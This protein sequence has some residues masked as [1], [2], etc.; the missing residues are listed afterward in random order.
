MAKAKSL[1]GTTISGTQGETNPPPVAGSIFAHQDGTELN[2][3]KTAGVTMSADDGR[4]FSLMVF[5]TFGFP[6][7]FWSDS[8]MGSLATAESLDRPTELKIQNRQ[9]IYTQIYETLIN[10]AIEQDAKA[11]NG[12]L[13][14]GIKPNVSDGQIYYLYDKTDLGYTV[15][16]PPI[17]QED[18]NDMITAVID[19]ITLRGQ[20]PING[21]DELFV[22]LLAT[23]GIKDPESVMKDHFNGDD[24]N[25]SVKA[26]YEVVASD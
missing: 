19:A 12:I 3:I 25:E 21:H 18:I 5:M 11:P 17:V 6:E 23:L 16:W 10:Y 2:P 15:L 1:L 14:I 9:N 20:E 8:K 7:T 26:F 24:M 4:R 13:T 22:K